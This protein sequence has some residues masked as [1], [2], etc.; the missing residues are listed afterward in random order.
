MIISNPECSS[1]VKGQFLEQ[2][3]AFDIYIDR[4]YSIGPEEFSLDA[5]DNKTYRSSVKME[6]DSNGFWLLRPGSYEVISSCS[7][8]VSDSECGYVKTRSTLLRN[9]CVIQSGLYD[10]GFKGKVG[11]ILIVTSGNFKVQKGSRIAQFILMT[12]VKA[13]KIYNGSY[14]QDSNF[15]LNRYI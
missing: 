13:K 14:G 7:V 9:G 5:N 4:V 1:K 12:G 8:E 3:N 10:S 15:D 6:P 2:P 11:C